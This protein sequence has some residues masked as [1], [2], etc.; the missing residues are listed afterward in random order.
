MKL[1]QATD[2]AFRM[3]LHMAMLPS[4]TKLSL[5]HISI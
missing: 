4:G 5:I 3:V 1:N 2:Y